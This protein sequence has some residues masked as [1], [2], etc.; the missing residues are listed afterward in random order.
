MERS[1]KVASLA[2]KKRK[3]NTLPGS[4][5]AM[6]FSKK[7]ERRS[8]EVKKTTP[9]KNQRMVSVCRQG[10]VRN[11]RRRKATGERSGGE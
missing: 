4:K 5:N 7:R 1:P 11:E 10:K 8:G 3:K 9:E 6:D 2:S